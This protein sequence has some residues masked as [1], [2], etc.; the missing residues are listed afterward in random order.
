MRQNVINARSFETGYFGVLKAL[1]KNRKIM[2]IHAR[3]IYLSV[4]K[5]IPILP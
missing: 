2:V 3:K 1:S 5:D 4:L